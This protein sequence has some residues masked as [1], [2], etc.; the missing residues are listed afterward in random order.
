MAVK[1]TGTPGELAPPSDQGRPPAPFLRR[2]WTRAA[3]KLRNDEGK[4]LEAI[5]LAEALLSE[6][7]EVSGA[8]V[9]AELL[10]AY[11]QL[12]PAGRETFFD[13]LAESFVPDPEQ[14][15]IAAEAYQRAPSS[16]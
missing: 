8:R 1:E 9:G 5:H 7:G 16:A 2:F 14:V 15:A 4:A 13:L 6:R 10:T 11:R 3:T 12:S